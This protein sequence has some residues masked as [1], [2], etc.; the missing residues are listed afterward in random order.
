MAASALH[1]YKRGKLTVIGFD[2]RQLNDAHHVGQCRDELLDLIE[3]HDCQ[4]LVVDL[5][6]VGLVSSWILGILAAIRQ[7][8]VSVELYHPSPDMRGVLS[9]TH[10]DELLHV[11]HELPSPQATAEKSP[12]VGG[13]I[14]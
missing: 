9:M 3:H 14:G 7:R 13:T 4:M 1:V 2:G 8:G 12:D 5:S 10:L 6:E 11:R